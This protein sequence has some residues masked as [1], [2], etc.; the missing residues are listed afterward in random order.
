MGFDIVSVY[1]CHHRQYS[2]AVYSSVRIWLRAHYD[3]IRWIETSYEQVVCVVFPTSWSTH[4][5]QWCNVMPVGIFVHS[6]QRLTYAGTLP[7]GNG[8]HAYNVKHI[9][10]L[11]C[12]VVPTFVSVHDVQ[13]CNFMPSYYCAFNS[14][15]HVRCYSST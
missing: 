1:T 10:Q 13:W 2:S 6:A 7:H 8:V 11:V 15:G 3:F 5:A 14:M 4:D 12:A 9:R